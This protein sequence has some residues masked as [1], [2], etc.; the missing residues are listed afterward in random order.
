VLG[1]FARIVKRV[2]VVVDMTRPRL[3]LT[4]AMRAFPMWYLAPLPRSQWIELVNDKVAFA[5]N[6]DPE[7]SYSVQ[8]SGHE[9]YN[10]IF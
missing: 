9:V 1:V 4:V 3:S 2:A 10:L 5:T 6:I 7:I 8:T